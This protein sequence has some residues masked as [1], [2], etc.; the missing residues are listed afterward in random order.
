MPPSVI[1]SL[2]TIELTGSRAS[3]ELENFIHA[4]GVSGLGRE[5]LAQR[6]RTLDEFRENIR[7]VARQ[8]L[9][10][11]MLMS[12]STSDQLTIRER[13]FADSPVTPAVRANDTTD[14]WLAGTPA[15]YGAQ[16][17][18]PFRSA[19]IDHAMYGQLGGAAPGHC[20]GADLGLFSVTLNHDV[21][22][23]TAMLESYAQF[24][25]E[26]E[27]KGFR[28]FLEVF[29]PNACGTLS[30]QQVPQF[31]SDSIARLLA[32]V[33]RSERPIFL[34]MP[35]FGPG[36]MEA[37]ASY[38]SSLV[39]GVLGGSAGTA[40]DAFQ[41]V[42]EAKRYGARAALF[43]RKINQAEHQLSFVRLLRSVADEQLEP[44]QAVREYHAELVR[45][46]IPA[47]RTLE[48]DLVSTA[49]VLSY[50]DAAAKK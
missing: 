44:Q 39:V 4:F 20:S 21:P 43:G 33:A 35:Y 11:I 23:D 34:K 3:F 25:R 2:V 12:V 47:R 6:P 26:A 42:A 37:L 48:Q 8:Q 18:R 17:A 28:H 16:P 15:A 27:A 1:R 50:D 41:L 24:R 22:L 36:P 49:V 46:K 7:D 9:V 45:L 14:I 13:L 5:P 40:L 19:S 38:D 29:P 32:G 31:V 30:E 10:D